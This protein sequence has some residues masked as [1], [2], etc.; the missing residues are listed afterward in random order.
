MTERRVPRRK[1]DL[2][3]DAKPEPATK[4]PQVDDT[5][6]V[7]PPCYEGMDIFQ[8]LNEI[9]KEVGYVQKDKEVS[10]RGGSYQ[11]VTHDAVTAATRDAMAKWGVVDIPTVK[12]ANRLNDEG[13]A[14]SVTMQVDFYAVGIPESKVTVDY[15]ALGQDYG[16]KA[17]GKAISMACKYARLK[18]LNLETGE[19]EESRVERTSR[20]H[21]SEE[22]AQWVDTSLADLGKDTDAFVDWFNARHGNTYGAVTSTAEITKHAYQLVRQQIKIWQQKA[23]EQTNE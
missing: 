18:V 20:E 1:G 11:V 2:K 19:D 15:V 22:Q 17:Y 23:A 7:P 3:R 9:R 12:Q 4:L 14:V 16:D 8:R 21:I 6:K 13:T 10:I 5:I